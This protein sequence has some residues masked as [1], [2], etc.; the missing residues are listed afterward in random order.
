MKQTAPADSE[1]K[2]ELQGSMPSEVR[3]PRGGILSALIAVVMIV[4]VV[5]YSIIQ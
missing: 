4:I 3:G 2:Q 5:D 1:V